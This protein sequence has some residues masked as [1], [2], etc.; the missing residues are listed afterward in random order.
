M[1]RFYLVHAFAFGFE[2]KSP[3]LIPSL[4]KSG[5]NRINSKIVEQFLLL[6][7]AVA[8]SMNGYS[9]VSG[10][11][12]S[13]AWGYASIKPWTP[14]SYPLPCP[15]AE[16]SGSLPV[17]SLIF[18]APCAASNSMS[19]TDGSLSGFSSIS[20]SFLFWY[21]VAPSWIA[22][23]LRSI[24]SS[25]KRSFEKPSSPRLWTRCKVMCEV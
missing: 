24:S 21:M 9:W 5:L 11:G 20:S 23:C 16:W 4:T 6:S 2:S 8:A 7:P 13:N 12:T 19:I 15:I 25:S 1:N 14:W 18:A 10:S 17:G 22:W 3:S